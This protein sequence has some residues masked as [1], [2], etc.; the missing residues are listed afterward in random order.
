MPNRKKTIS[1]FLVVWKYGMKCGGLDRV[2]D[3]WNDS[4][5]SAIFN[6]T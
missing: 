4:R 1:I 3:D 2:N 6:Y 5:M